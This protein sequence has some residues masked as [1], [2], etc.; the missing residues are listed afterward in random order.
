MLLVLAASVFAAAS[1]LLPEDDPF[2]TWLVFVAPF[3]AALASIIV[4]REP[5][6]SIAWLLGTV[7]TGIAAGV[8][9][10]LLNP[11][12]AP[13]SVSL[14]LLLLLVI[15]QVW[16]MAFVFPILLVPFLFPTG[17]FLT[18]RWRWAGWL[19]GGMVSLLLGFS[20]VADPVG[21]ASGA[22][23]VPN[24]WG[25]LPIT[26]FDDTL[27]APWSVGLVVLALG[28]V[29]ALVV[30][31]RRAEPIERAQ[32]KWVLYSVVWFGLLYAVSVVLQGF[33]AVEVGEE[34]PIYVPIF[35]GLFAL[36]FAF[37]PVSIVLAISR[38][39]LYEI[40]RIF[41]RTVSY[42]LVI[43]FLGSVYFGL[44]YVLGT[45]LPFE[46]DL[47]VATSTL[48]VVGLFNPVR[49]RI[50]GIVDR[51]FDRSRYDAV[52]VVRGFAGRL[53]GPMDEERL[54]EEL[55]EV[56]DTTMRPEVLGVWIKEA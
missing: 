35:W 36:S 54:G 38:Y 48:A 42:A 34:A 1:G 45:F 43:A 5:G 44:L 23:T 33:V 41:S 18:P 31:F 2:V 8:G 4:T 16:W 55:G 50:H 17:R 29:V 30:R 56:L 15:D 22:W 11:D 51:R 40:D 3:V 28:G 14:W 25:V 9:V 21:P 52:A 6:N 46:S 20:L 47:A 26:F 53:G 49:R 39:R 10:T 27:A 12:V 13:A 32:I 19:A 24:P 37:I 7:A